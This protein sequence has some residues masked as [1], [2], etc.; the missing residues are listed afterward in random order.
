MQNDRSDQSPVHYAIGDVADLTGITPDTI[1]VWERR[2]GKPVPVRLPSGHRRYTAEHVR[3]I[4]RI[5]EALAAGHRPSELVILDDEAL[6]QLLRQQPPA[7]PAHRRVRQLLDLVEANRFDDL[8][9]V[10]VESL[11]N[12]G[13][14][15]FLDEVLSPFLAAVGRFW[16]DGKIHVRHEHMVS[17]IAED[18]LRNLR[19]QNAVKAGTGPIL[20]ATLEGEQHGIGILMAGL[21]CAVKGHRSEAIGVN[22]PLVDIARAAVEQRAIGVGISVS[23]ASGGIETDR[24]L[25]ELRAS[26][27]AEIH[28]VVGGAGALSVRRRIPGIEYFIDLKQFEAWL[29]RLPTGRG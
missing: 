23:L 28:L 4:R 26:L 16:A 6:D 18:L 10:F 2:Y 3:W 1:R 22:T 27:P 20:L 21:V 24:R 8:R 17:E 29:D 25:K 9:Q 14:C 19:Q 13:P 15:R 11:A 5:S 12:K 7:E